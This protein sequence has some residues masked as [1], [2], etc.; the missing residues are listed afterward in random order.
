MLLYFFVNYA[1][2]HVFPVFLI[3]ANIASGDAVPSTTTR[4][5]ACVA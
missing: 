1:R 2:E 5:S 4:L 3:A